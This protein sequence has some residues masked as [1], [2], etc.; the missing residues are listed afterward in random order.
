MAFEPKFEKVVAS[1][2]KKLNTIQSQVDCKLQ[3]SDEIKKII[4]SDAKVN[5]VN[6][7]TSGKDVIYSGFVNF[8]VLYLT[9]NET[10]TL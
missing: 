10:K 4:F 9:G 5:I 7:E 1:T 6:A 3:T 8:Q 2:R